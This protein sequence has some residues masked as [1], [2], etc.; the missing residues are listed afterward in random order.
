MWDF[1]TFVVKDNMSDEE[2]VKGLLGSLMYLDTRTPPISI[3]P[4]TILRRW[5]IMQNQI[6]VQRMPKAKQ[7]EKKKEILNET[8]FVI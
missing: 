8:E 4:E 3:L 7:I 5:E 2:I 6:S 1:N